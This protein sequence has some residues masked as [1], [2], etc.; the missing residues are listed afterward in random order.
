MPR[1]RASSGEAEGGSSTSEP[2]APLGSGRPSASR[3]RA[4]L[5]RPALSRSRV[6]LSAMRLPTSLF[7]TGGSLRRPREC[8]LRDV[9]ILGV[10]T[11]VNTTDEFFIDAS[12]ARV[13]GA[14][15]DAEQIPRWWPKA[16]VRRD[17]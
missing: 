5:G 14:L 2:S 8:P 15:V 6:F 9:P 7:S 17:G 1:S 16:S 3:G 13:Y 11:R 10:V 12:P 4:F